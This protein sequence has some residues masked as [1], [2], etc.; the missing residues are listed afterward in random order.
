MYKLRPQPDLAM[1]SVTARHFLDVGSMGG[2]PLHPSARPLDLVEIELS[3]HV[4]EN[5][6]LAAGHRLEV[7][8]AYGTVV[9][10]IPGLCT[11]YKI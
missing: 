2:P 11:N 10:M 5:V 7:C 4:E 8:L 3:L 1:R 9:K 6:G